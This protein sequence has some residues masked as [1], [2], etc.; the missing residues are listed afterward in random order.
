VSTGR[1]PIKR[2][3]KN[4]IPHGIGEAASVPKKG[5]CENSRPKRKR[6]MHLKQE[7]NYSASPETIDMTGLFKKSCITTGTKPT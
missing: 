6:N 5:G 4:P 1:T 2:S 7:K 3:S